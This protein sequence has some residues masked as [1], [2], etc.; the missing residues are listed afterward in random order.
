MGP[1]NIHPIFLWKCVS[2][3]PCPLFLSLP[4]THLLFQSCGKCP[5]SPI[6]KKGLRNDPLNYKPISL[7]LVLCKNSTDHY[8]NHLIL[9][10]LILDNTRFGFRFSRYVTDQLLLTHDYINKFDNARLAV[11]VILFNFVKTFVAVHHLTLIDKLRFTGITGN[12]LAWNSNIFCNHQTQVSIRGVHNGSLPVTCGGHQGC[13]LSPLLFLTF[14]N[15][16]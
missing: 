16:F 10:H 5:G 13:V 3:V 7:S 15:H 4:L 9:D 11:D 1:N 2:E 14:V 12:L 6:H 8:Q